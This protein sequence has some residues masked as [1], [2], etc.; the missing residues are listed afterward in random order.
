MDRRPRSDLAL[1][2]AMLVDSGIPEV[3]VTDLDAYDVVEVTGE[4]ARLSGLC[5]VDGAGLTVRFIPQ[6][7]AGGTPSQPSAGNRSPTCPTWPPPAAPS[8]GA[9]T[10]RS[11]CSPHRSPTSPAAGSPSRSTRPIRSGCRP[12]DPSP[13]SRRPG[14]PSGAYPGHTGG[15]PGAHRRIS[16]H[17]PPGPGPGGM[18]LGGDLAAWPG[19]GEGGR[20][21][22]PGGANRAAQITAGS[23][24]APCRASVRS[25][26]PV[27]RRGRV[28]HDAA[29]HRV[30]YAV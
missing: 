23:R 1:I 9:S 11:P 30:R 6:P 24:A 28:R 20:F 15:P 26:G 22:A 10:S 2:Y 12:C 17:A 14:E 4:T 16:D 7:S 21:R 29:G 8:N 5:A 18:R 27:S 19:G 3:D 13:G 25:C